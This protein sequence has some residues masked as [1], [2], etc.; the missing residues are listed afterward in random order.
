MSIFSDNTL[1]IGKT[2][3]IRLNRVV[4]GSTGRRARKDRGP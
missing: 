3:L 4:N 2:P 1:S